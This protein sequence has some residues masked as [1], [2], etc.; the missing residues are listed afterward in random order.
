MEPAV[1]R[2][3][4]AVLPLAALG[5]GVALG[6]ADG[7]RAPSAAFEAA[8]AR[9]ADA[10]REW[11]TYLGDRAATHRSALDQIGPDNV[12]QLEVAWRYDAGGASD[13]GVSQIQFNPLVVK[14]VLYGTS[15]TLRLFAL[16][17]ATGREL[18]SFDP[19][20]DVRAWTSSRGAVYWEEGDDERI[21]YGAGPYLYAVDARTGRPVAGFGEG[22]RI[23]LR[24]GLGRD[25]GDD[26][27]GVVAST[28]GT[29]FEDLILIGGRVNE[30]WGAA[31]GHVRAF[32]IRTGAL[33]WIFHTIPEPGEPGYETWPADAHERIGGANAWAGISVDVARG[34]AYVPTGSAVFDYYGAD[35]AGDNLF[36]NSL[37][38]LDARTGERIWHYQ[39]VRHDMW[40]RDLPAPP[41]LVE[42]VRDGER[43]PAVAQV[44]KTGHTFLFHRETGEPLEP[45][46]E[47]PVVGPFIPGEHPAESQPLPLRPPPLVRQGFRPDFVTDYSRESHD[48][49]LA[50]IEGMQFGSLY[51]AFGAARN[52]VYPGL[53]GGAEWGGAAWDPA[54]GLLYVNANQA[55]WIVQMIEAPKDAGF[56][57][58]L[59]SG[60]LFGCAGCH[61]LDMKGDGVSVPSLVDIDERSSFLEVYDL[62][63]NGRGRMP[64]LGGRLKWYENAAI[65]WY[66]YS[67]D[68]ADAPVNWAKREGPKTFV[69]A[70]FQKLV[71]ANGLPG[72]KPP[73]GTLT[74]VD[75]N[76]GTLRWQVPLGDYPQV[77]AAGRSGLGAE[78]YGGPVL[79]ATGVLFL[80][81]T[82]DARIRAFDA[83]DGRVL[84]EAELPACGFATPAT[85]EADGRQFVVVAAGGGKLGQPSGSEY[86][87]FALGQGA[88]AGAGTELRNQETKKLRIGL[89]RSGVSWFLSSVPAP[90]AES[91]YHRPMSDTDFD[92]TRLLEDATKATGF[93]DFGDPA[94]REPFERTCRALAEEAGLNAAGRAA[95]RGRLVELLATR[96]RVEAWFRRHP[97]ISDERIEDPLVIVGLP[98]TGTTMLHR[99]I[100]ADPSFDCALWYETRFPAPEADWDFT[101]PDP[102]IARG[103]QEVA[104][105]LAAVPDLGSVHPWDACQPDEEIML[106]EPSFLTV[107]AEAYADIPA[108]GA[109]RREQDQRPSYVVLKRSLQL[110]QWQH[111]KMGRARERWVLKAPI[112][113]RTMEL[114]FETFPGVTVVQTHREPLQSI[115]SICSMNHYLWQLGA[116]APDAVSA[117]TQWTRIFLDSLNACMAF[118]DAGHD[119]RFLDVQF[120]DTVK[121]PIGVVGRIYDFLG[122]PLTAL[123][124]DQMRRWSADNAREKRPPHAYTLDK[125]G[126]SEAGIERDFGTYRERFVGAWER[127]RS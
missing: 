113:M 127:G 83:A 115:P 35:R 74:A 22:G 39:F 121:D 13:R 120:L 42:V 52:L 65:A 107:M 68:E 19:G 118:R 80:A 99:V 64:G 123:A 33:R 25:V 114:L 12:S 26:M 6:C 110:L 45:M 18:W 56:E 10:A 119:E 2:R 90:A 71:D 32:D 108:F 105:T 76:D 28:P 60:Y 87:A 92:P 46:R 82:P 112:H 58:L 41:N 70:G 57:G 27:M 34:I 103:K 69:N 36:A 89:A 116:D 122:K 55:P 111:R 51:T 29:V 7:D 102:R 67:A 77:L 54:T 94:F 59:G 96:A 81:A 61:G 73:W 79:T 24:L 23:D 47:E 17:A 84:W 20:A 1:S 21:L 49:I 101:S 14:G 78:N 86:V 30:T 44:T 3:R 97:E 9:G 98:R 11:R 125:F 85:Y 124:E 117:G 63:Q 75:L 50:R 43:I 16:D 104:E 91:P 15:P 100:A 48:E 38:A 66:V 8:R 95:Q 4:C 31:P 5:L 40:D 109:W 126:L 72:S 62:V 93:D 53:D 37:I 88:A 106:M